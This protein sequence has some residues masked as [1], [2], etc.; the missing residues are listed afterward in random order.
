MERITLENA[1]II[2]EILLDSCLDGKSINLEYKNIK[3]IIDIDGISETEE[4]EVFDDRDMEMFYFM[5]GKQKENLLCM[6]V[7]NRKHCLYMNIGEWGINGRYKYD[8]HKM[9]IALG[10][11]SSKFGSN[12]LFSQ[13][14]IS[15]ALEDNDYVYIV[16]NI[17]DLAGK[18]AIS[19]LNSGLKDKKAKYERRNILVNRLNAITKSYEGKEWIVVSKIS[20]DD[21]DDI[22]KYD[23]IFYNL[24]KDILNYSFTI[25]D[26]IAEDK[27]KK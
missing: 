26:I 6:E 5:N 8:I 25:E 20:K 13:L 18:G 22:S 1:E 24:I 21:L 17:S 27:N 7:N 14:E 11:T 4:S 23:D 10:T 15:Q 16:K 19:R 12:E 2:K 9:H 3:T